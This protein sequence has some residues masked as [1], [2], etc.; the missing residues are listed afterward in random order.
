MTQTII[1]H[2]P[3]EITFD[4]PISLQDMRYVLGE[5]PARYPVPS[6]IGE[7]L[8]LINLDLDDMDIIISD[9]DERFDPQRCWYVYISDDKIVVECDLQGEESPNHR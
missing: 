7:V 4:P 8:Y 6:K 9:I 1:H 2:S 3:R 5:V